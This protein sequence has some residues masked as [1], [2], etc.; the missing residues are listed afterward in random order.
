MTSRYID[1]NSIKLHLMEAG[2]ADGPLVILLHGFPEFWYGWRKQI[3]ALAAAGYRVWAPDQRGY[4]LSDKPPGIH[5]YRIDTLA[6]DI[7][8]L[9][10]AAG[11]EKAFLVGHDWGGAVA[12]WVAAH[13]P[14]RL[15]KL[16]ILNMPHPDVMAR[17]V[18]THWRQTVRSWYILFFQLPGLPEWL[19][20]RDQFSL[21][22]RTLRGTSRP[23]TFSRADLNEYR[24]AW[25]Q[26]G[27]GGQPAIRTMIHWYRAAIQKRPSGKHEKR[28]TVPT[29]LLWGTGDSFLLKEQAEPS[30]ARCDH[31]KLVFFENTTHWIQ[32]EEPAR[33]SEELLAFFD[34]TD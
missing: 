20:A 11:V 6:A 15:H 21:F 1:T 25:A 13:Y 10:N 8:G 23:G 9:I 16:A 28:I 14:Q 19:A 34:R 3:E 33:V 27:H 29:L 17:F 5:S 24:K 30:L 26:P 4:N 18:R 32:H 22:A 7:A 31:G 2:P 12:W